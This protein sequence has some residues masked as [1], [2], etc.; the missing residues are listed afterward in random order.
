MFRQPLLVQP[1]TTSREDLLAAL[2]RLQLQ[3]GTAVGS[4]I[5][6]SLKAIFPEIEFNLNSPDPRMTDT[7]D[8][9]TARALDSNPG[10]DKKKNAD[11]DFKPVPPG[12][13]SSTARS[14][15]SP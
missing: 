9:R 14:P 4:G 3:Y 7:R 5:L 13:R 2:D 10:K 6:V 1:P 8:S 15:V 12:S 11:D